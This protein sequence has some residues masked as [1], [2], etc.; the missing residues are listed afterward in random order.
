M[1][2]TGSNGCDSIR[3]LK[4]NTINCSVTMQIKAFLEGYY[5]ESGTMMSTLY[6]LGLSADPTATD[7]MEINLWH[8]DSLS[9]T[10]PTYTQKV[11]LHSNGLMTLSLPSSLLGNSYY[12]ALKHR[13]SVETW[14][15]TPLLISSSNQYDFSTSI[16]AAFGDGMNAPM[17]Q[18]ATGVFAI[19]GGDVNQDGGIDLMDINIAENDASNFA[20]GYYPS[21]M[22]GDASSDLL[23]MNIIEN[24][25]GQFIFYVRPY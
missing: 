17:K 19:Y 22:N 9:N 1:Q 2:Y 18:V 25:A 21:D 14:T 12:L 24:N 6:D 16:N 11:L 4:L 7:S 20:Y 5:T 10:S 8:A 23:D 3:I 13:S 15:A